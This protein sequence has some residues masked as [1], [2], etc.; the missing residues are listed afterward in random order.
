[1]MKKEQYHHGNLR[2][3]LIEEG[4]RLM[5]EG[6]EVS[7]RKVAAGCGVSQAAPYAHFK[8]K[9]DML[10]AMEQHV[11][12]QLMKVLEKAEDKSG[13]AYENMMRLGEAYVL[14][15]LD[16]PSYYELFCHSS[17]TKFRIAEEVDEN[18]Y[19]P[20][21]LFRKYADILFDE[22]KIYG[23]DRLYSVIN[24]W[25]MVQGVTSLATQENIEYEGDWREDLRKILKH[26]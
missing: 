19:P 4:I 15:F 23:K 10:E 18:A 14:F 16:H 6:K 25:A 22:Y 20:Y 24:L 13:S 17:H 21:K 9:D 5:S 8:N 1:M 26:I 3:A 2:Q 7:L 12:E 11:L